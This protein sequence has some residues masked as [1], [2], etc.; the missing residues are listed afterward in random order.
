MG[1]R[2]RSELEEFQAAVD[3]KGILRSQPGFGEDPEHVLNQMVMVPT[4]R[5]DQLCALVFWPGL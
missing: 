1:R 4:S 2:L 3:M 5:V